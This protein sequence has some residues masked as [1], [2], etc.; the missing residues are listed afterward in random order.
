M[1]TLRSYQQAAID[2]VR[3]AVTAKHGISPDVVEFYAP[4]E[5]ARSSAGK[6]ARRVNA[7]RFTDREHAASK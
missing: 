3:S 6:I 5:I 7:K 2:A 4:G 1:L